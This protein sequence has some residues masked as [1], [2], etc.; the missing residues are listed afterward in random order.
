MHNKVYSCRKAQH[1]SSFKWTIF[2][3]IRP[4]LYFIR[5]RM[6][7][8]QYI[9]WACNTSRSARG[10][11][12]EGATGAWKN[13]RP[14]YAPPPPPH[15]IFNDNR[16]GNMNIY[17]RCTTPMGC[18][19]SLFQGSSL[20]TARRDIVCQYALAHFGKL[21]FLLLSKIPG[22][23]FAPMSLY[24]HGTFVMVHG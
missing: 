5:A 4:F 11:V 22:R 7:T 19:H 20:R 6:Q 15:W 16:S 21:A 23:N 13:V 2:F 12:E 17:V 3:A 24:C 10:A 8:Q 18:M 1:H 14:V 9:P